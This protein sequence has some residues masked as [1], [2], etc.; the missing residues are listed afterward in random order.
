MEEDQKCLM[1]TFSLIYSHR[2]SA[3]DSFAET[4]IGISTLIS[5]FFI[6]ERENKL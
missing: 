6:K 4:D 1:L 5:L 2:D 3:S